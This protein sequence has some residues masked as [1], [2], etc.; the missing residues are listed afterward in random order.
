MAG[1][2]DI[3]LR[4]AVNDGHLLR[5]EQWLAARAPF[6][7]ADEL[8]RTDDAAA[9]VAFRLLPKDVAIRTFEELD[10]DQQQTLL[11]GLRA[12]AFG[13]LV[14]AMA[15]DDRA[16]LL[17]EAPATVAQRVLAGLSP[18]ER[19]MTAALLGYPAGS[20]G[21]AMTPQMVTL[22]ADFTI[23]QAMEKIRLRGAADE[24][25][26]TL[27]VL[28]EGRRLHGVVQ[29]CDL[30]TGAPT[31]PL[32]DL[33]E[34]D[35]PRVRATDDAKDAARLLRRRRLLAL[36]VVDA[37]GRAVGL[38]AV[39]DAIAIIEEAD[40]EDVARQSASQPVVGH[41][42]SASV[43]RLARGRAVW[44]LLLIFA[45]TLTVNVLQVFEATLE[46]MTTLALFIPLLTGAGGNAGAQSAT[47]V[48]RALAVSEVRPRDLAT[49]A[50]RECRVG[51]LL[52]LVLAAVGLAIGSLLVGF[53]IA[54][55]VALSL[56]AICTWAATIGGAMPLL[57]RW[58]GI[59]PAMISAP[60]VTT[61]VDATGLII[62]FLIARAVL[63]I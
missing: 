50:W 22:P 57:A 48:V 2:E 13:E 5:V 62:Y 59:D 47:S 4:E 9:Q 40:T 41:Y 46:Q 54:V 20:V 56:V 39:D 26:Y 33:V 32:A 27:P 3:D 60:L 25:V 24:T 18:G 51:V 14:E 31:R 6:E 43:L 30:V 7:I 45:A 52:G 28:D 36:P 38:L 15:P 44:L 12:P 35:A 11:A 49:V 16:R 1:D 61:L 53:A 29:L 58:F 23:G 34:H 21:R 42:I 8:T 19:A 10:A 63:G 17:G 37:E 55:A